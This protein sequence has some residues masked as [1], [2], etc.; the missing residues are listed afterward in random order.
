MPKR[1]F[2]LIGFLLLQS[3]GLEAVAARFPNSVE[4]EII[5][6]GEKALE[7]ALL[8]GFEKDRESE[9]IYPLGE[10][11]VWAAALRE[12]PR[13][14]AKAVDKNRSNRIR[15]TPKP[16]PCLTLKGSW[17]DSRTGSS[18]VGPRYLFNSPV[19]SENSPHLDWVRLLNHLL[20]KARKPSPDGSYWET[21]FEEAI[22]EAGNPIFSITVHH[23][24]DKDV[25]SN[26][27]GYFILLRA[28]DPGLRPGNF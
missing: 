3:I 6:R 24:R 4:K 13:D 11:D 18:P 23:P 15:Y 28:N 5:F 10:Q 8:L 14:P 25:P 16:V 19:I 7:I 22:S 1:I 2:L 26:R 17:L 27:N 20:D 9:R 12:S 21:V